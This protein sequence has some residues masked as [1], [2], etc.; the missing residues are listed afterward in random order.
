M[1]SLVN[2]CC[3]KMYVG[4]FLI[5]F[6][7][8]GEFSNCYLWCC[9]PK[10]EFTCIKNKYFMWFELKCLVWLVISIIWNMIEDGKAFIL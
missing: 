1:K 2:H 5:G 6:G 9:H 8:V 3:A 10:S 4:L 7:F